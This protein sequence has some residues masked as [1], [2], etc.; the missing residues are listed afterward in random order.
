MG[1]SVIHCRIQ[2]REKS[3]ILQV[4]GIADPLRL[5]LDLMALI[6]V[7][8]DTGLLHDVIVEIR[9]YPEVSY[10]AATAGNYD[11]IVEVVCRDTAHFSELLSGRLQAV[12][13]VRSTSS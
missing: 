8:V 13:G 10:L 12:S 1:E 5:G 6:Q 11:L 9:E 3:G 2:R 7:R 4:V